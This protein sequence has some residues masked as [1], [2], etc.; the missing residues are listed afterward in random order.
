MLGE[1]VS[2]RWDPVEIVCYDEIVGTGVFRRA[3]FVLFVDNMMNSLLISNFYEHE[4]K[5]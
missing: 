4:F 1:R 2:G 5:E 3:Q